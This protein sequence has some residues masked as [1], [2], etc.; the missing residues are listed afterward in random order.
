MREVEKAPKEDSVEPQKAT[1]LAPRTF[2]AIAFEPER[3]LFER[4]L[5]ASFEDA[6]SGGFVRIFLPSVDRHGHSIDTTSALAIVEKYLY[7]AA[8]GLTVFRADGCWKGGDG[9]EVREPVFVVE[10]YLDA[11]A[12]ARELARF[13]PP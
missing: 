11:T 4:N 10:A 8:G 5:R 9:G 2:G 12:T 1:K 13:L 7:R 6:R 3:N